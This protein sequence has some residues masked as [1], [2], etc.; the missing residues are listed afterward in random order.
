MRKN[1]IIF[2]SNSRVGNGPSQHPSILD[3]TGVPA[4]SL[5][6]HPWHG[7]CGEQKS[8][9]WCQANTNAKENWEPITSPHEWLS[10]TQLSKQGGR[11]ECESAFQHP[12]NLHP[13]WCSSRSKLDFRSFPAQDC[14]LCKWPITWL[15]RVRYYVMIST[16]KWAWAYWDTMQFWL[17]VLFIVR[18]LKSLFWF[19]L[20]YHIYRFNNDTCGNV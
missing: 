19:T 5:E 17:Q 3:K 18:L 4:N 13:Q 11:H 10:L 9:S 20:R 1:H 15:K 7:F 12:P 14:K 8:F 16:A 6:W 2:F